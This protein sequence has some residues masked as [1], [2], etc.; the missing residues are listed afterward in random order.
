MGYAALAAAGVAISPKNCWA[1]P[2]VI[3]TLPAVITT[4]G[5]YVLDASHSQSFPDAAAIEIQAD[6]VSLDLQGFT[7]ANTNGVGTHALGVFAQ[8]RIGLTIKNGSL[9]GF[10]T[11]VYLHSLTYR[12][13]RHS[14]EEITATDF[15]AAGII[16]NGNHLIIKDNQLSSSLRSSQTSFASCTSG[17]MGICVILSRRSLL[18]NNSIS[19]SDKGALDATFGIYFGQSGNAVVLGSEINNADLG[20]VGEDFHGFRTEVRDSVMTNVTRKLVGVVD[21]GNNT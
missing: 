7:I 16:A 3:S 15:T 17:V 13:A 8:D 14:V 21:L 4:P 18:M 10:H 20:I 12:S 1:G 9:I 11:A 5:D 6:N 2:M 19:L